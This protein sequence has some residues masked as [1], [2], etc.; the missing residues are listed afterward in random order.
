M[1]MLEMNSLDAQLTDTFH[2]HRHLEVTSIELPRYGTVLA[3]TVR[4]QDILVKCKGDGII[5]LS[6]VKSGHC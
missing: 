6:P 5:L 3:Q 4:D 1:A 2:F